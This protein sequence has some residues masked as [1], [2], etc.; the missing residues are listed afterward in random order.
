[1]GCAFF[2][3]RKEE[4]RDLGIDIMMTIATNN[5][6]LA[7][8]SRGFFSHAIHSQGP[9]LR[10]RLS[11]TL[12]T[13]QL[14]HKLHP[15]MQNKPNFKKSQVHVTI[16]IAKTYAKMGTWSQGEN[17]PKRTQFQ[18]HRPRTAQATT[19][20]QNKPNSQNAGLNLTSYEQS[21]YQQKPPLPMPPKQT[22]SNPLKIG[23]YPDSSGARR[24]YQLQLSQ[25]FG[26]QDRNTAGDSVGF[27]P[28]EPFLRRMGRSY[29]M[30]RM[31]CGN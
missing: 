20:M 30:L 3:R 27:R 29:E 23:V 12:Y 31:W 9:R 26:I 1:M 25:R 24:Q 28:E 13:A 5:F 10:P 16:S 18:P 4:Y 8:H 7:I 21:N 11:Q 14:T 15:F 22:Q 19:F 2:E 17:E 6:S